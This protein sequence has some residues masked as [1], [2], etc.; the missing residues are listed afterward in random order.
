MFR[1]SI[2]NETRKRNVG[3]ENSLAFRR[4]FFLCFAAQ[5]K[6]N[7]LFR[8]Q[9]P[10]RFRPFAF[11]RMATTWHSNSATLPRLQFVRPEQKIRSTQFILKRNA[12]DSICF[13]VDAILCM[14][15]TKS[16]R[17]SVVSL[18]LFSLL[19]SIDEITTS[20]TVYSEHEWQ[21]GN[22]M[23]MFAATLIGIFL[24]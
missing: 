23:E 14:V 9:Q 15:S 1:F 21:T 3:T 8:L 2:Y 7:F 24:T 18:A 16:G 4:F 11:R 20:K 13:D 6:T 12:K 17:R 19:F 22:A 10:L 5:E